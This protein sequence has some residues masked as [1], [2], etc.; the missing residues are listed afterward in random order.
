M[1]GRIALHIL[2]MH[3]RPISLIWI[4]SQICNTSWSIQVFKRLLDDRS[5]DNF[6][7]ERVWILYFGC[8]S[9]Q[10][11]GRIWHDWRFVWHAFTKTS[12][13]KLTTWHHSRKLRIVLKYRIDGGLRCSCIIKRRWH[14]RWG[15][16]RSIS[17]YVHGVRGD[18]P[19]KFNVIIGCWKQISQRLIRK[20]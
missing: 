16:M 13:I 8:S 15:M 4:K 18:L 10:T 20:H 3:R 5:Q 6:I 19:K 7:F 12:W 1:C 17:T 2:V 14:G 9:I 11:L